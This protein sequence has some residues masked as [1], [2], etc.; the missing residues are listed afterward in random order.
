[1]DAKST[2]DKAKITLESS[3]GAIAAQAGKLGDGAKTAGA[4]SIQSFD[5]YCVVNISPTCLLQEISCVER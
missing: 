1:M 2:I 5:E 4:L 3:E